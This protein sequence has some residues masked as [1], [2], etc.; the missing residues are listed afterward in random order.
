M[1]TS[2]RILSVLLVMI[3]VVGL[4]AIPQSASANTFSA[5]TAKDGRFV[6]SGK[7]FFTIIDGDLVSFNTA[8]KK[9]KDELDTGVTSDLYL[10]KNNLYYQKYDSST[11]YFSIKKLNTKTL[12][13]K[14][15]IGNT[16]DELCGVSKKGMVTKSTIACYIFDLKG[17]QIGNVNCGIDNPYERYD[18]LC[19]TD[20]SH[21]FIKTTQRATSSNYILNYD[22][23]LARFDVKTKKTTTFGK[24]ATFE[25]YSYAPS[26]M[27]AHVFKG[28][29]VFTCGIY[30][31]TGMF[32]R[33]KAFV[34]KLNGTK[35]KYINAD[36][37]DE[38]IPGKDCVYIEGTNDS[39]KQN[40]AV[41]ISSKGA[42][43]KINNNKVM[44]VLGKNAI[45]EKY[46]KT[47]EKHY[48]YKA[49]NNGKKAKLVL[50]DND[51]IKK[52]DP[53]QTF[54]VP[55]IMG[56]ADNCVLVSYRVAT[57]YNS[58]NWRG[59]TLRFEY[60]LINASKGKYTKVKEVI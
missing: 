44:Y 25:N 37:Q 2:K 43:K 22:V 34:M 47:D 51:V 35:A 39:G 50:S 33:G 14:T 48:L 60:Y 13:A 18:Y 26:V 15:I 12:K 1:K 57:Y 9:V 21:F 7:T 52:T 19:S 36:V 54:A 4:F 59:D 30:E 46:S 5:T 40:K 27:D 10:V 17:K 41:K 42:V 31:G 29:I 8:G 3:F 49:Q 11:R 24:I 32:Y 20:K 38:I 55:T 58:L 53:S 28:N 6:K 16:S 23:Y 45:I 56:V